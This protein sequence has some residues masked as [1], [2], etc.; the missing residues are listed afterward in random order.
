MTANDPPLKRGESLPYFEITDEAYGRLAAQSFT[1]EE[2]AS[3]TLVLRGPCPRC[4]TL[5]EI[6][7]VN[8]IFRSSRTISS[9]LRRNVTNAAETGHVEPMM[10]TCQDGHAGRP[11]GQSG[12]GA[13]WT[14]TIPSQPQ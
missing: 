1:V 7:V 14:L 6:P 4:E 10:C 2:P 8:R 11:E 13:Y 9:R 3:G 5:I 12:C